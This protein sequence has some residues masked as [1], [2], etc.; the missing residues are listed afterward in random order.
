[1]MKLSRMRVIDEGMGILI[2]IILGA[3]LKLK[4]IILPARGET[5]PENVKKI[6][7]QKYF[8]LGS[9]LN[10]VPLLKALRKKYPNAKIIFLTLETQRDVVELCRMA[11][12]VITI[13]LN[14]I[15]IFTKDALKA[16]AYIA[17]QRIDISIDL[18]FFSKFTLIVSFFTFANI[19]IGLHQKRIRPDGILTHA[20]FYNPYKHL[21]KIYF[22]YAAALGI[23]YDPEYF[24]S[25]LPVPEEQLKNK[26]CEKLNLKRD[27]KIITVNVNTSDLFKF[28]SWPSDYFVELLKSLLRKYPDHQ[29]I[30]IGGKGDYEHVSLIY[31]KIGRTGHL[32]NAAG[33]TSIAELFALIEISDLVITN[34]SGPLHI[35]SFYGRDIAAFFGP[36][37]PVVYGPINKNAVVFYSEDLYCSP[38]M[39]VYDSKKS[40][41]GETCSGNLC[42]LGIKPGE[43]FERIEKVFL[44]NK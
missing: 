25:L 44:N 4:N 12:E 20:I 13:R 43:V 33:E 1:M 10:S 3:I 27:K 24:S 34:D 41:Y 19:R 11:D 30:L 9:I 37:N 8:G 6:L 17:A 7:C 28:R 38:C 21:S 22:S 35:A 29:Y 32:I 23:E 40:L 14:S 39:S 31:N 5:D 18:E 26:L 2:C 42:L 16:I 15:G 36:E